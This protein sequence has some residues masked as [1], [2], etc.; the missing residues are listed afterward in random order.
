MATLWAL[1]VKN[2]AA[3]DAEISNGNSGVSKN[4]TW[5]AGNKQTINITGDC[6]FAF[7]PPAGACNLILK[8][9]WDGV[10]TPTWPA[11]VQWPDKTEPT[12]TATAG[13]IDVLCLF[14]DGTNYYSSAVTNLGTPA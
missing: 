10:H 4:I 12:W 5:T 9:V 3:F 11:T 8:L 14:Y 2:A 1:D 6:V 7:T 13:G